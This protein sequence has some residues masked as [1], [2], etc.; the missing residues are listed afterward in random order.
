MGGRE[1]ARESTRRLQDLLNHA[2]TADLQP[3]QNYVFGT[4]SGEHSAAELV[5]ELLRS[6]SND[7]RRL[8]TGQRAEYL[9]ILQHVADKMGVAWKP[10]EEEALLEERILFK[11]FREAWENMRCEERAPLQRLF[12]EHGVGEAYLNKILVEGGVKDLLPSVAILVTWNVARIL[13]A[14]AAQEIGLG[15][16]LF[17]A[18]GLG[19]VLLGPVGLLA[20]GVVLLLNLLGPAYRKVIPSVIHIAYLRQR[21][22]CPLQP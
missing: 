5:E 12:E 7:I 11:V 21:G 19:A 10:E 13:A 1:L 6:G 18:E 20:G 3:L 14:V 8:V 22:S 15:L 9:D 2:G 17:F 4:N 16:G